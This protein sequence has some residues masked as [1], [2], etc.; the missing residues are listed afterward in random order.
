VAGPL[1]LEVQALVEPAVRP[2]APAA[3]DLVDLMALAP[4]DLADTNRVAPVDLADTNRVAPG[5][6]NRV[7]PGATADMDRVV[8]ASP[9]VRVLANPGDMILEGLVALAD[10]ILEHPEDRGIRDRAERFMTAQEAQSRTAVRVP[11]QERAG[12]ALTPTLQGRARMAAVLLRMPAAVLHRMPADLDRTRPAEPARRVEV[13]RPVEVTRRV[14]GILAA[15][16]A[17]AAAILPTRVAGILAAAAAAA[18][19]IL[20]TE[21]ASIGCTRNA[22]ASRTGQGV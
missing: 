9:V 20:P 17:A 22:L 1:A 10:M 6:T 18:A 14:A 11:S 3:P 19:A 7:A 2:L 16:A 12:L 8:L 5:A 15:A 13:T 4:V 21:R